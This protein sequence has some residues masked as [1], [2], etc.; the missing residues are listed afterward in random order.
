MASSV[1]ILPSTLAKFYT[2]FDSVEQGKPSSMTTFMRRTMLGTGI[3]LVLSFVAGTA[4]W[5]QQDARIQAAQLR[6]TRACVGCDLGGVDF[7]RQDLHGV[8]LADAKLVRASFYRANLRGANLNG[9]DLSKAN[10]TFAD[11]DN[12]NIGSADLTGANL[13]GAT[14][15]ALAAAI[16]TTTTICPDGQTGPCR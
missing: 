12:A 6:A 11:L 16:T 9:A 15:A 7:S 2:T 10:L 3:A 13:M 5:A 8:D 4:L 14:S 1:V